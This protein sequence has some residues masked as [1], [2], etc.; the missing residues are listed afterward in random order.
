MKTEDLI[1][2]LQMY[3]ITGVKVAALDT[4]GCTYRIKEVRTEFAGADSV[5]SAER[6]ASCL[7]DRLQLDVNEGRL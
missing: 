4:E 6:C 2:A 1:R 7:D 3:G 5:G